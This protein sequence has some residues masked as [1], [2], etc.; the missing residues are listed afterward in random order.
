ME[1][2]QKVLSNIGLCWDTETTGLPLWKEPSESPEQPHIVQLAAQLINL[3]TREVIESMDVI[4]KPDG[5]TIPDE[6][7]E[8]HGI[9][10]EHA[11]AVGIP[12]KEAI[13]MLL[14]MRA[15]ASLRIAH[16]RT[17]DDRIVRI[18]LK[19]YFDDVTA[20]EDVLQP[21]DHWKDGAAE[22][23]MYGTRA[24]CALPGNKL[25]K[26]TEAHLILVGTE[27]EGAHNAMNDVRGCAA[28]YF[29]MLDA[30]AKKA[31]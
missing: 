28:V 9:T 15:K 29:A 13:S 6:T 11:L 8:I 24:L 1:T 14:A 22:C 12:E 3:D 10:Q 27:L 2:I 20:A 25:P 30:Q 26:L 17:F 4:V 18:A 7:V 21:S 5:W 16:N 23:T 31:A 19:R